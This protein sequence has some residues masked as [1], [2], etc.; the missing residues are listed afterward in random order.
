MRKNFV[1]V[2]AV[3][4]LVTTVCLAAGELNISGTIALK[5]SETGYNFTLEELESLREI[6]ITVT[7]P[8]LGD[9]TYEG[10]TLS[11]LLGY[12]G[13]PSGASRV[14]LICSDGKEFVLKYQDVQKF[15]IMLAYATIKNGRAGLISKSQGGPL[16]VV[17]P[18][19]EF[20]EVKNIY[21]SDMWAWY[22]VGIRV[23]V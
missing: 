7:D 8:W 3:I 5:N 15:P 14:V 2:M 17:Y 23:E 11:D 6:T 12:V 18:L 19:N 1:A 4:F 16:K 20:P 13:V 21:S 10:T 9:R 22:I